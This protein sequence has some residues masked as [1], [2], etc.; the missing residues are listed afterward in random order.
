LSC[1]STDWNGATSR[2]SRCEHADAR[3]F[4]TLGEHHVEP[5]DRDVVLVEQHVEQHREPVPWPRP[6]ALAPLLLL[7]QAFFV[8]VE[9]DDALLHAARHGE[10]QP[11]VVDDRLQVV[12]ER[13]AVAL[14]GVAE[15]HDDQREPH[16]D[17]CEMLSQTRFPCL[18]R[19]LWFSSFPRPCRPVIHPPPRPRNQG[20]DTGTVPISGP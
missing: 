2:S 18:W 8:D 13:Q 20:P 6:A 12:D 7:G 3:G 14:D 4:V 17:A 1:F 19:C 16:D 10:A 15:K 9:D 11:R 5:D